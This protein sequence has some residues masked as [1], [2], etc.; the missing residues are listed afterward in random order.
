M[1]HTSSRAT[2]LLDRDPDCSGHAKLF[3]KEVAH[4]IVPALPTP[5]PCSPRRHYLPEPWSLCPGFGSALGTPS[6][7]LLRIS[8][9]VFLCRL[10]S[11]ASLSFHSL[12]LL[13]LW[14]TALTRVM[15]FLTWV[16]KYSGHKVLVAVLSIPTHWD[17]LVVSSICRSPATTLSF[18]HLPASAGPAASVPQP[19]SFRARSPCATTESLVSLVKTHQVVV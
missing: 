6:I 5:F 13:S 15:V 18:G 19:R 11:P 8:V 4:Q 10:T 7:P 14:N 12:R 17:R 2:L 1:G 3:P 9:L 16:W